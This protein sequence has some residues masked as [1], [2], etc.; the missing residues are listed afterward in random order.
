[1]EHVGKLG[2][3][4][5]KIALALA[6]TL[7]IAASTVSAQRKMPSLPRQAGANDDHDAHAAEPDGRGPPD[8][9]A[10]VFA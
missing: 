3:G 9:L 4:A 1:M 8:F 7:L 2:R 5:K 10:C 6:A